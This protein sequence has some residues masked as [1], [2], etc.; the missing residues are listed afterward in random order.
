M[1]L[2]TVV[3]VWLPIYV[4]VRCMYLL[5]RYMRQTFPPLCSRAHHTWQ[6]FIISKF[7]DFKGI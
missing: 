2:C 5:V 4:C 3:E 6:D 1:R 7:P